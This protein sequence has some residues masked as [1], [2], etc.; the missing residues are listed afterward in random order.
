MA[1]LTSTPFRLLEAALLMATFAFAAPEGTHGDLHERIAILTARLAA[2]PNNVDLYLDRAD[3]HRQHADF[4]NMSADLRR[5][6]ALGAKSSA[7]LRIEAASLVDRSEWKAA[8]DLLNRSELALDPTLLLQKAK[9]LRLSGQLGNAI[10]TV[11]DLIAIEPRAGPEI[12]LLKS[13]WQ[14]ESKP[15]D[16]DT[17]LSILLDGLSRSPSLALELRALEIELLLK[18]HAEAL[19]RIDRIAAPA[20]R[21][22]RWLEKKA[23]IL[24]AAGQPD[25]ARDVRSLAL[26]HIDRLPPRIKVE[27][28]TVS[29]RLRLQSA[30]NAM[31]KD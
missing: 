21:K 2:D 28:G 8:L 20:Q 14:L 18:R 29:R 30:M 24:D 25:A 5:A 22:D 4:A 12:Y 15:E 1:P 31:R 17:A 7:L 19:V 16:L 11:D 3:L 23:E 27:P 6:E 9:A 13:N 10:K 26:R